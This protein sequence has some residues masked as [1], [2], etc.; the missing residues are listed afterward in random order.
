M[1]SLS[2]VFIGGMANSISKGVSD[3]SAMCRDAF[4]PPPP[5]YLAAGTEAARCW[6]LTYLMPNGAALPLH[7]IL[8]PSTP[9]F[10]LVR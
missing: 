6:Q 4:P 1:Y 3:E 7:A 5:G 9:L 2:L 10:P 8:L